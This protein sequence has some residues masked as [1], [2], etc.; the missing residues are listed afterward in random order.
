M[1]KK[2]AL[3]KKAPKYDIKK[4]FFKKNLVKQEFK[5]CIL[6]L[7]FLWIYRTIVHRWDTDFDVSVAVI[8]SR[9]KIEPLQIHCHPGVNTAWQAKKTKRQY[10]IVC[11]R[12]F[13]KV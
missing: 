8:I 2:L 3:N 5:V 10:C 7:L 13:T 12:T 4:S 11:I 1:K 6:A 9:L